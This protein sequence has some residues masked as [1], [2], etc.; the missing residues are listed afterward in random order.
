MNLF[1]GILLSNFEGKSEDSEPPITEDEAAEAEAKAEAK[2]EEQ[3]EHK[4]KTE[5][6]K[7]EAGSSDVA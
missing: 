1:L 7:T 3:K 5:M 4:R 6:D 2:A